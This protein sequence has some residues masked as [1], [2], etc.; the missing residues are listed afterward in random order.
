[1]GFDFGLKSILL[2]IIIFGGICLFVVSCVTG[3]LS[4]VICN[5]FSRDSISS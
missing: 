5:G 2:C 3:R 1:M 4:E